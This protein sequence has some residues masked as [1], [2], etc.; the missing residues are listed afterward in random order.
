MTTA[1]PTTGRRR[2]ADYR[3]DFVAKREAGWT[4]AQIGEAHGFSHE[5]VRKTIGDTKETSW[6]KQREE[7]RAGQ[8]ERITQYVN[9]RGL[10]T[11]PERRPHRL[12]GCLAR[13]RHGDAGRGRGP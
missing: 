9:D 11:R 7:I 8:I 10:V 4:Y 13:W 2:A 3:A 6:A 12:L 5:A 1:T